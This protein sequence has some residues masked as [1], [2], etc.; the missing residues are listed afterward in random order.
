MAK[1]SA[2]IKFTFCMHREVYYLMKW[3]KQNTATL[4]GHNPF[5]AQNSHHKDITK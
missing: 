5:V 1:K 4:H 3:T 2:D